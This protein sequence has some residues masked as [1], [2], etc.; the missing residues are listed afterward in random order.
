[1]NDSVSELKDESFSYNFVCI[2][3]CLQCMYN[4]AVSLASLSLSLASY[5]YNIHTYKSSMVRGKYHRVIIVI[6]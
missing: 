2:Y 3:V 5:K 6:A 4:C 1:M